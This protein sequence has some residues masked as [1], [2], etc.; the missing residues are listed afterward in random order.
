MGRLATAAGLLEPLGLPG[1][2]LLLELG[3]AGLLEL[4][5]QLSLGEHLLWSLAGDQGPD[6]TSELVE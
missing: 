1:P 2:E 5:G 3:L 4:A 6:W